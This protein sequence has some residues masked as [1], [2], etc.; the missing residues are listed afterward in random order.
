MFTALNIKGNAHN[1]ADEDVSSLVDAW[2]SV[3][4]I[5]NNG[6]RN[7]GIYILKSRGIKNSNQIREFVIDDNGIEIVDVTIGPDGVL[8]GSA[9]QSYWL[10]KANTEVLMKNALNRKEKEIE[11]KRKTLESKI[12]HLRSEF[13]LEKDELNRIYSE[14]ELRKEGVEKNRNE[15]TRL[16]QNKKK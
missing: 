13:D 16:R 5:E 9:R 8:T 11:N 4:D 15:I 3:E 12:S 10:E 6:E 2:L 7:R 14:E 1:Q